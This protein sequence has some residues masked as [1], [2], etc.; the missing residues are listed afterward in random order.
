MTEK[1]IVVDRG[2]VEFLYP[3]DWGISRGPH[4]AITLSDPTQACRLDVSYTKLPRDAGELPLDELLRQLLTRVPEAGSTPLIEASS[5]M[6]WRYAWTDYAY[7]SKDKRTGVPSQAHGRWLLGSNDI[8]QILITFHYWAEDA[9]WAVLAW[10]R[11]RETVQLGDGRQ[12]E[13]PEDHWS[14]K[15]RN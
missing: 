3:G 8:F 1:V 13:S 7:S 14:M 2:N 10:N 6:E 11:I 9:G 15:R 12:L 5:E 4:G